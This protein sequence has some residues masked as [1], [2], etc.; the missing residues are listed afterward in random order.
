VGDTIG[1]G[2]GE[3][4]VEEGCV[5]VFG[6]SEEGGE[7]D[8]VGGDELDVSRKLLSVLKSVL[9]SSASLWLLCLVGIALA[10]LL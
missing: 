10:G 4:P 1:D 2:E 3:D 9:R 8:D 7:D 5:H 6:G